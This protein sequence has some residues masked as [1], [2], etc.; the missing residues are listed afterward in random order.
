M[1]YLAEIHTVRMK[2]AHGNFKLVN[3]YGCNV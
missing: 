2:N 3:F 1:K